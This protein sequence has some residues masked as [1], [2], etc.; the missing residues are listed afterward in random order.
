MKRILKNA[1]KL[2]LI[3]VAAVMM[4]VLTGCTAV[5][6]SANI[7]FKEDGSGSR[8]ITASIA[9]NDLQDGYG[10]AYYYITKHGDELAQ[11]LKT[12][13]TD[14]VAG[15][16]GWLDISVD[17]SGS[18][19][20]VINFKF[21]FT[22]F[23]D[24]KTKLASLA[25]DKT[26]AATYAAPEL[27]LSDD[28]TVTYTEN[29][30]ALTAIFKSI[31]TTIMADNT[32]FDINS[33]KDG[34]ATNDGSAD[35]KSLTDY[36]VELMK[37]D[38]GNAMTVQFGSG[39]A[40]PVANTDGVFTVTGNYSGAEVTKEEHVTTNVLNYGFN[41]DLTNTGTAAENDL[42]YGTGSTDGG[43]VF[44]EGID[45]QAIKLDGNTYLASPNKTYGYDQMTVS[46]YYK[47]DS[48][49]QTDTGANMIIVPAGLGALGAG[50]IDLEFIKDG[51]A[52]GVQLL[53]KMNSSDWQTQDKLYSDGYF[54][55][56]HLNEWHNYTL[57][58]QNEYDEFGNIN[59]AF[60]YMYIDGQLA[61]KARLS[62]AAGLTYTLGMFDDGSAGTANGGFNVGGYFENGTVKRA[63]TGTLDNFLVFD[64]A[65]SEEE[66]NTL[67][68]TTA[69]GKPYDPS[70]V[71]V[72]NGDNG[73]T[74][75]AAPTVAPT[76]AP[77]A[78][79]VTAP[80]ETSEGGSST[81]V[82]VIVIVV[83]IIAAA[84]VAGAIYMKKKR[85]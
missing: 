23:D 82:V 64:G 59:D 75:A 44:V 76:T 67:C 15:S 7:V 28:G 66:I 29:A 11:Y 78:V 27:T 60:V 81:T 41:G 77:T 55:D 50:V 54:M 49:T 4:F 16:D 68:Y 8:T 56:V 62:V 9:K 14:K 42:T 48:Y 19:W 73:G 65:L 30:A 12:T 85:K 84:A 37:P 3:M 21:D 40:V 51:E 34:A 63:S 25:Y 10:S 2:A 38:Y 6:I 80:A 17:D 32:M 69:V 18:D 45:G 47:M 43:P 39:E 53:T 58:F 52:E 20:E 33:T 83:V 26:A 74:D 35:L 31:Q 71:D 46:F 22:S 1:S 24:Y 13:Y 70:V 5:Q 57:V 72:V 61:T 79:P 36:G